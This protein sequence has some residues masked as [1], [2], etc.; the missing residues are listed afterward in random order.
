MAATE[1]QTL[2]PRSQQD[3]AKQAAQQQ[4]TGCCTSPW[5]VLAGCCGG[6]CCFC[7]FL[8]LFLLSIALPGFLSLMFGSFWC[9]L[10]TCINV[11]NPDLAQD[12]AMCEYT[13]TKSLH[14]LP[15][16]VNGIPFGYVLLAQAEAPGNINLTLVADSD[17]V[18]RDG[19]LTV[20]KV[21]SGEWWRGNELGGIVNNPDFWSQTGVYPQSN[22]LGA[23]P[24]QHSAIRKHFEKAFAVPQDPEWIRESLR[25]FLKE[26]AASGRLAVRRDLQIWFYQVLYKNAF[27][28]SVDSAKAEEFVDVQNGVVN[29]ATVSQGLSAPLYGPIGGLV[30]I[31]ALREG[32][33][34]HVNEYLPIVTELWGSE[35]EIFDCS[36]TPSCSLQLASGLWDGLYSAGGLSVPTALQS[37]LAV[38]YSTNPT[39]PSPGYKIPEGEELS[40]YWETLR[41]MP[42]VYSFPHWEV[43]RPVCVNLSAEETLALNASEGR[44][45]ACPKQP[46]N[47][48]TGF[49]SVNQ[50]QGGHRVLLGLVSAMKDPAIWG[51]GADTEFRVRPLEDYNKSVGFAEMAVDYDVDDGRANRDCPGKDLALLVG[52]IFWEEF[53]VNAWEAVDPDIPIM[54]NAPLVQVPAFDLR[55]KTSAS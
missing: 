22:A 13:Y 36:P 34:K 9:H 8:G 10:T 3:A 33:A 20:S 4:E 37:G 38:L 23:N 46:V 28:R 26:K 49:P 30:G 27:G 42:P 1:S 6:C 14:N 18:I 44:T 47:P 31:P 24:R 50:W 40:F 29:M 2:L 5:G 16:G 39:N 15:I 11:F 12:C 35:L 19:K 41:F 55:P 52:K 48:Q 45:Q 17:R 43:S 54:P 51:P 32:V 21:Y 25:D 7:T 53:D